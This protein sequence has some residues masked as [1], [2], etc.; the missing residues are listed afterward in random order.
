MCSICGHPN[1]ADIENAILNISTDSGL[2]IDTIAEQY[3]LDI[4]ELRDHALFHTALV[5]P[6]EAVTSEPQSSVSLARKMK[7]RE[8]DMLTAV[9]NEYMVTLKAM[10]RR[11]NKLAN[12]SSIDAEDVEK[13][14]ELA[15]LLTK[16]MVDLYVGLGGEIRQNVRAMA[17]VDRMLNGPQDNG[18]SG[19]QALAD[20]IRGSGPV[21]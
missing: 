15:K 6:L 9:N 19:L 4:T 8:A 13:R 11:I 3:D 14:V 18:S 10:G 12:V 5:A 16:P 7:L 2:T 1:R 21:D 17:E 20:A